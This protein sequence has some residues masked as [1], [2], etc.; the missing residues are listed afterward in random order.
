MKIVCGKYRDCCGH[1]HSIVNMSLSHN[2]NAKVV[3]FLS[4]LLELV[5]C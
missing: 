5:H 3:V 2:Q 4:H 1:V